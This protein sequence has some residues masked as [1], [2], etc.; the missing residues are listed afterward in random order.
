[1]PVCLPPDATFSGGRGLAGRAQAGEEDEDLP[2][3]DE[4]SSIYESAGL[5]S[6]GRGR[7]PP[8]KD[9]LFEPEEDN[10]EPVDPPS[11][12]LRTMK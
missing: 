8:L 7:V 3:G 6:R 1:M 11:P 5:N 2:A 12:W 10:I 4:D 9:S